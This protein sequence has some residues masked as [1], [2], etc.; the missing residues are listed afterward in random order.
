MTK[1]L[2]AILGPD[3]RPI[4]RRASAG[5]GGQNGQ[6]SIGGRGGLF[7]KT[8][9][10][11]GPLDKGAQ[12]FFRP[13]RIFG[14]TPLEVLFVQSW[15]AN[16]AICAP[17]DDTFLRWREWSDGDVE[18]SGDAMADAEQRHDVTG[19]LADAMKA[20]SAYG[21]GCV[22]M[23]TREAPLTE[24]L[25]IERIR[26]GD[27]AALHVFDRFDMSVMGREMDLFSP[28]YQRPAMYR[29]TPRRGGTPF[30][31]HPSR[32]LRFDGISAFSSGGFDSYYDQD[33]GVS[34]LIPIMTS[35]IEDQTLASAIAHLSQEA[36]VPILHIDGLREAVAG[37][38]DPDEPSLDEIGQRFNEAK[39]IWNLAMLDKESEGFERVAVS[40]Q[41]LA[42]L[43]DRFA[44]RIA[45]ARDIPQTRFNGN[46]PTGM[47]ATGESDMRNYVMMVEAKRVVRLAQPLPRLDAVLARDAGLAEPPEYSWLSLIELSDQEQAEAAHKLMLAY[48]EAL[49]AYVVT[50]DEVRAQLDGHP[51][52]GALPD[53]DLDALKPDP[54]PP[55]ML[56]GQPGAPEPPEPEP[57]PDD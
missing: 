5:Y 41:G 46:P 44:A 11:G 16:K 32:V 12:T 21:T 49:A 14:R 26:E 45:M 4:R 3:G 30:L 20:G 17:V 39:S 38:N 56:P 6:V 57:E 15:A 36:S 18:G 27:L 2:P 10:L 42:N 7:N 40:F 53:M 19:K 28:E 23:V 37:V 43:M 51:I 22:V 13:T 52:F 29:V 1:N 9:G 8:T 33:W 35:L 24:P 47:S 34:E 31:V 54:E 48:K 50:E 25:V 55:P